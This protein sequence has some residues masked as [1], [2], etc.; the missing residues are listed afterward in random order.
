MHAGPRSHPP[1]EPKPVAQLMDDRKVFVHIHGP[2]A[3]AHLEI[4]PRARRVAF[5]RFTVCVVFAC[6]F[7]A[8]IAPAFAAVLHAEFVRTAA[9]LLADLGQADGA[10]ACTYAK[11]RGGT[12]FVYLY[13]S[14]LLTPG[15]SLTTGKCRNH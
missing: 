9:G 10:V 3:T 5:D 6:P 7:L 14:P 13:E 4:I 11:V 2:T 15:A 8:W 1:D 12:K